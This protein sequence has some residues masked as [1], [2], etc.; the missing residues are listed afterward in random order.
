M[1]QGVLVHGFSHLVPP[2]EL[3]VHVHSLYYTMD[4][5]DVTCHLPG[6]RPNT[7]ERPFP[8]ARVGEEAMAA[9]S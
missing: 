9:P 1:R 2:M 6:W 4:R 3:W 5:P 8:E 7:T